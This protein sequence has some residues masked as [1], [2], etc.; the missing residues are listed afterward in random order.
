MGLPHAIA[1]TTADVTDR[2]GAIQ[3]ILLNPSPD[4]TSSRAAWADMDSIS[5]GSS[6][7]VKGHPPSLFFVGLLFY[8]IP[9]KKSTAPGAVDSCAQF[10]A[11]PRPLDRRTPWRG[12]RLRACLKSF[13]KNGGV[14]DNR[15]K[16]SGSWGKCINIQVISAG[17]NIS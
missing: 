1:V 15:E 8:L 10:S 4:S 6:S 7:G 14:E 17:K 3:M 2:D 9:A 11:H 13:D 16:T 5:L 12:P